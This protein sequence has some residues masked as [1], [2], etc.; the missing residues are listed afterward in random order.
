MS[1]G[2]AVSGSHSSGNETAVDH[3]RIASDETRSIRTQE[4]DGV[5]DFFGPR[6]AAHRVH[7]CELRTGRVVLAGEA[8]EHG[9]INGARA[10]GVH[11]N[12]LLRVF[13]RDRFRQSDDGMLARRVDR[14]LREADDTGDR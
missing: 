9:G 12:V 6:N 8:L 13:E 5:S 4:Q 3:K 14:N 10:Y 7:G 11:A 2:V 1:S